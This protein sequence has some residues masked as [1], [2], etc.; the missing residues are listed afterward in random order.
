[1][2][3]GRRLYFALGLFILLNVIFFLRDPLGIR[4]NLKAIGDHPSAP[5]LYALPDAWATG[6]FE[7]LT[8]YDAE[9]MNELR[10]GVGRD[11]LYVSAER[12]SLGPAVVSVNPIDSYT[13]GAASASKEGDC[14]LILLLHEPQDPR[15]ID[16]RFAFVKDQGSGCL[17]AQ[18]TRESVQ[19]REWL[20]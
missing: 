20:D 2:I 13:W 3:R 7:A 9:R 17:G 14:Y 18:A 5:L 19:Q 8:T 12:P 16:T 11:L 1:M 15:K 4:G 10:D 6:R